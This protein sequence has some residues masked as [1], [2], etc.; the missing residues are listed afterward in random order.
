MPPAREKTCFVLAPSIQAETAVVVAT[1][2]GGSFAG[3]KI[4]TIIAAFGSALYEG[5][6]PNSVIVITA[7]HTN[8]GS[9]LGLEYAILP[10]NIAVM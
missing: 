10:V 4:N 3:G 7:R 2:N 1:L 8:E 9:S 6:P 5:C